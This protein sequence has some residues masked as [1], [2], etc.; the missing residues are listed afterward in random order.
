MKNYIVCGRFDGESE[1]VKTISANFETDASSKLEEFA[2]ETNPEKANSEFYILFCKE[3]DALAQERIVVEDDRFVINNI[4]CNSTKT[5]LG[6][7]KLSFM[8]YE[9][10]NV[11][12]NPETQERDSR[13]IKS[14]EIAL[15]TLIE[16][17]FKFAKIASFDD[18]I[19][20]MDNFDQAEFAEPLVFDRHHVQRIAVKCNQEYFLIYDDEMLFSLLNKLENNPAF[21]VGFFEDKILRRTLHLLITNQGSTLSVWEDM[22]GW[23]ILSSDDKGNRSNISSGYIMS[24]RK[25][26]QEERDNFESTIKGYI[27][28]FGNSYTVLYEDSLSRFSSK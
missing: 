7:Y 14:A 22:E 1:I 15:K 8:G 23:F 2:I 4:V 25:A 27:R 10:A 12:V 11:S 3:V 17:G 6:N 20:A 16:S 26:T 21:N 19:S 13:D 18:D 9:F 5:G 28:D 24:H